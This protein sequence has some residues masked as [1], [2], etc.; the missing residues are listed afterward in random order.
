M[1]DTPKD[2]I[3][4]NS[5]ELLSA[6]DIIAPSVPTDEVEWRTPPAAALTVTK[7]G[8]ALCGGSGRSISKN[9]R[10]G[11]FKQPAAAVMPLRAFS[12]LREMVDDD[13]R[14]TVYS[15]DKRVY[16]ENSDTLAAIG[17]HAGTLP[18][19]D[20]V[21]EHY[22]KAVPGSPRAELPADLLVGALRAVSLP[23]DKSAAVALHLEESSITLSTE[24][25]E[26][27]AEEELA[28][29]Q[30]SGEF[31]AKV[32]AATAIS[33]LKPL[34]EELISVTFLPE[35]QNSLFITTPTTVIILMTIGTKEK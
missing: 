32:N 28:V 12:V 33:I 5:K 16:L 10:A 13:E 9:I 1:G 26:G 20:V 22:Q 4:L 21:I 2:G 3:A 23:L 34:G 27:T 24:S 11:K 35:Q 8:F 31:A 15:D 18:P 29:Q 25:D 7:D 19:L 14:L 6:W 30:A 17:L